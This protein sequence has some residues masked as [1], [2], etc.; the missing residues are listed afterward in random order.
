[1][2][3]VYF[4]CCALIF[5]GLNTFSQDYVPEL[6]NPKVK[7][8][9]VVPVKAYS[10]NLKDVTITGGAFKK[11]MDLDGAYLLEISPDRLL[12]RFYEHAG[13]PVKGDIYGG[14]ETETIS[15]HTLG[16]YLSAC[17]MMYASTGDARYKQKC[18]YIVDQLFKCQQA[19]KTGYVG[20]VPNEDTVFAQV[21][22]GEIRS[23][24]FD[25]NGAWVPWYTLHKVLA[26][27]VDTYLYCDNKQALVIVNKV[28]GWIDE[29]LK[30]LSDAQL[31]KM[32]DCEHGGMN[33]ILVNMYAITGNKNY[34]QLSYKFH[35]KAV[36]DSLAKQKDVMQGRHSN[37]NI[38]KIIGAQRRYELTGSA[39]DS[40]IA[41]YF[42]HTI[43]YHHSYVNGGNSNYEYLGDEDKLNDRLSDNTT[44]TCNTYNMLKLTRHLFACNP[45]AEYADFYERALY[46][47]ILASQEPDSGMMC[48]FVP[49]RMGGK[50]TYSDKFNSFWCCVGS[51]MEN[52]SKYGEAIYYHSAKG[53]LFVNLFIPSQL[54]WKDK[55]I[56][57]TQNT[58]FPE[59]NI[60][61]LTIQTTKPAAFE[62][63]IRNPW[64]SSNNVSITVNNKKIQVS[65][66]ENGY[67]VVNRTWKNNDK[68]TVT[69][70]MHLY[71][72]SMPDNKNRVAL[73]YGP[74]L[75]AGDLGSIMPDPVYGTPVLLTSNHNVN[76]WVKPLPGKPLSFKMQGVG[77]PFDTELSPFYAMHLHYFS[78][79]WDYFTNEEWVSRETSYKQEKAKEKII[80]ERTIDVMRLGEMQPERDH[81]LQ[82]SINSYPGDALTRTGREAR[83]GGFFS[84]E[85]KVNPAVRN[86]LLCTYF[87][88]D[89]NRAFD[90]LIDDVK[91]ASVVWNGGETGKFYDKEYTLPEEMIKGKASVTVRID[92]NAGKTAG[93]IFGCR[94]LS[95]DTVKSN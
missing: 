89:K 77:K 53:G 74:V 8:K 21:A 50:K 19:R 70:D 83:A 35:H 45:K 41:D 92:A 55:N 73:L 90:I 43:V 23:K 29:E 42:W 69:F 78:V 94:I 20:A 44:E 81:H 17:A 38:P 32:L 28:G 49:L 76:E 2:K 56:V 64:W 57:I 88:D 1:M 72:E 5:F 95:T 48:Y 86:V 11:A 24:G 63:F 75:L 26:G 93:R 62:L 4:F 91:L 34:L 3:K 87:G 12:H 39:K 30:G 33:E 6:N 61:S 36:L 84:F 14:W 66:N 68:V 7:I 65:K 9:P 79:Y 82:S 46:N 59:S 25:L 37:T 40:T 22:R 71:T 52:H 27:L 51:G 60:T 80:D 31:Q 58:S 85:I 10:F 13:L 15:G 18:S 54:K 16:H 47:H 67:F